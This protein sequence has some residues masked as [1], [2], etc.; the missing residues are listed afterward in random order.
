MG[1]ESQGGRGDARRVEEGVRGEGWD[2]RR[3]WERGVQRW[4]GIWG[5]G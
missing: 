1:V 3:R 5:D 2:W 4:G